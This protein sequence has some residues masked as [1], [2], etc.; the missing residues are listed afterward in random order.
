MSRA[1]PKNLFEIFL[2]D[3]GSDLGFPD[4]LK[5]KPLVQIGCFCFYLLLGYLFHNFIFWIAFVQ[6]PTVIIPKT[7]FYDCLSSLGATECNLK[8]WAQT[9]LNI[10]ALAW[11]MFIL[12]KP[13]ET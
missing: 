5:D 4:H 11:S 9:L 12:L 3:S 2:Y 8:S 10:S 13:K 6:L 1:Q 7:F